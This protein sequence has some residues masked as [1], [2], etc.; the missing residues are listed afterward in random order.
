MNFIVLYLVGLGSGF[1]AF[2][3]TRK[4]SLNIRLGVSIVTFSAVSAVLTFVVQHMAQ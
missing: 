3:L 2:F 4:L 1:A